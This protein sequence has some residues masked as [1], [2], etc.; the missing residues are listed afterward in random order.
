MNDP[1]IAAALRA[2]SPDA[3]AELFDAY[4]DNMFRYCLRMLRNREIAQIAL[5]DTL[6]AAQAHIANLG[7]PES[8]G[9]W[10]YSLARA[11]CPRP[12]PGRRPAGPKL[13]S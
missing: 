8:L 7:D 6:V 5:R 2:S 9:P 11:E 12:A 4:G 3:L 13:E 1:Q 10:L